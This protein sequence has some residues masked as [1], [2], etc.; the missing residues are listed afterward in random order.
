MK[1]LQI[2]R[3]EGLRFQF[4]EGCG[5]ELLENNNSCTGIESYEE[6]KTKHKLNN[7]ID[8]IKCNNEIETFNCGESSNGIGTL[9]Q[10]LKNGKEISEY[11]LEYM[12]D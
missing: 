5:L 7:I 3:F 8:Q 11:V 4:C 2:I 1:D 6:T 10:V 12:G 9:I